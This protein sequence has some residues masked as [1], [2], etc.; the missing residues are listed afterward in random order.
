MS[1][2]VNLI[3]NKLN[4]LCTATTEEAPPSPQSD[5]TG[6]VAGAMVVSIV[7]VVVIVTGGVLVTY[8]VLKHKRVG[9]M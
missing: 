2:L 9:K 8:L 5:N 3:C 7:A 6:I 1:Y 4:S